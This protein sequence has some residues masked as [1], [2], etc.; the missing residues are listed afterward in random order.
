MEKWVRVEDTNYQISN[1]GRM[2]NAKTGNLL[3]AQANKK[4]Y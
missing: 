4:G 2:V 1:Y 3:K